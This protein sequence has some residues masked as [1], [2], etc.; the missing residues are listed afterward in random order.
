M[1]LIDWLLIAET[2]ALGSVAPLIS[3]LRG[4]RREESAQRRIAEAAAAHWRES[5][6]RDVGSLPTPEELGEGGL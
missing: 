4:K 3:H 1:T 5:Y 6:V 2:V